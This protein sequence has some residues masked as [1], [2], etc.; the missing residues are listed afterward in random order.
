[1]ALADHLI[2]L[3]VLLPLLAGIVLLLPPFHDNLERQ[4]PFVMAVNLALLLV[5]ALLLGKALQEPSVYLLG[6]WLP[7]FGIL[8]VADQLASLMLVLTAILAM[9]THWYASAGDDG[10]G[11]FFQPLF[12]FQV[13][14]INGAFLTADAFNLFVFFEV[15][16][17]ASYALLIHG[18]G[19]HRTQAAVH[20]VLLN[21]IGS[22]FF[23][24]GLGILYASFGTL[25]LPDMAEKASQL[26][27]DNVILAKAGGLLLL[28]VFGL[29]SAMLPLHF[30]L[31]RTYSMTSAP[32][33]ALFAI[34]T[35]VGIYSIWR[36]HTAVFG[37][38]AGALSGLASDWLWVL[39]ILTIAVGAI[40]ALASQTL[41]TLT[42]NLVVV[43]AGTLLISIAIG[44]P[45]AMGAAIYYLLHST[46]MTAALFLLAGMIQ[47]Q[48]GQAQDRF[49][50]A[51][52]LPQAVPLGIAFFVVAMAVVGMPPL[53]GFLGKV[54]L[55]QASANSVHVAWVWSAILLSGLVA[56]VVFSRAGTSIFWRVQ[57]QPGAEVKAHSLQW[58]ALSSLLM[59]A[60][61][62]VLFAG[63]ITELSNSAA[64]ELFNGLTLSQ[65]VEAKP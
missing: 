54:W 28:L 19:K 31:V 3:P 24:I 14:G 55:L 38:Q 1:V 65:L 5:A 62:M 60:V 42:A 57:G 27:P 49:V 43:S 44:T 15:L 10:R 50:R 7:P 33:A 26:S 39:G 45:D 47:E 63:P 56:L 58:L 53:S 21:L 36:V 61:L 30:W 4:R 20:Y 18:G 35:K 37:D 46:L 9:T 41:K 52:P 23:L 25:N 64:E 34:M 13:M 32:V 12:M 40:A 6:N 48:R 8:L 59:L 11:P 17:I 22:A 29:K 2:F 51:K 16:L